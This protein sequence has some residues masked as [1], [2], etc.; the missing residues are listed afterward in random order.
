VIEAT[1]IL[2]QPPEPEV[3]D[4]LERAGR[5]VRVY[6]VDAAGT[7]VATIE[8]SEA[9]DPDVEGL[10]ISVERWDNIDVAFSISAERDPY[11]D[12]AA[13]AEAAVALAPRS[14]PSPEPPR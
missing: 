10:V 5:F 4:S 13:R 2:P 6:V 9:L 8:I 1:L 14:T 11:P 12:L 3:D 7:P